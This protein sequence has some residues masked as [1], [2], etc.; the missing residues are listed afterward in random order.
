MIEFKNVSKSY[1]KGGT[2]ALDNINLTI[3]QG[4]FV[5]I[6]GL[7]GAGKSTLIK[8]IN[9]MIDI[10]EGELLVNGENVKELKGKKLRTY[11]HKIAMIFQSY[12][13]V[14]RSSV[15]KNVLLAKLSNKNFFQSAFGIFTKEEK[16]DALTAL[17]QVNILD[18]AY[19]RADELS[20]G[21]QQ[22]VA[23]ARALAQHPE[24]LLADEPVAALDPRT[25]NMVMTDFKRINREYNISILI[26]IHHVD[27][28]LK[29]TDRIIG[30]KE[31]RVVYDGPSKDI[32]EKIL[33]EIYG[34]DLTQDDLME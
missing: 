10:D 34:R 14:S 8:T 24:I 15:L 25:A 3:E 30:I 19:V 4:E 2:K 12:N 20:G 28:A 16:I 22:R 23:L 13:L 33:E 7:S 29:Y 11:R 9:K 26:N 5:G 17:D 18:K 31:G 6:I 1:V 32:N 27:L 21:Q